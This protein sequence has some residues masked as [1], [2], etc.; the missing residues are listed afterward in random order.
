MPSEMTDFKNQIM[1]TYVPGA[2][3]KN[4]KLATSTKGK[5]KNKTTFIVKPEGLSQGKGIFLTRKIEDIIA[6][7]DNEGC[8]VQ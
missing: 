3:G 5:K 8:V 6:A 4:S 7:S 1:D 2:A